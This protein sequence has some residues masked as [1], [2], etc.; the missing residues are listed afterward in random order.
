VCVGQEASL[1]V[2]AVRSVSAND[3]GPAIETIV[4]AFDADPVA[5]WTWPQSHQYLAGMPRLVRALAGK[6]FTQGGA[7]CTEAYTG[8]AL[9]LPP[10]AYP[11]EDMLADVMQSTVSPSHR[12]EVAATFEQMAQYHPNEPHW[13]LP[14]IGVDPAYQGE[15]HGDALMAHALARCDRDRVPAYLESTNPRNMSLYLRHGFK[16]VGTIQA[17]SSPTLIPMLRRL[18]R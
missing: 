8:A 4:L 12:A 16:P 11:D 2:P 18:P 17:G 6:A 14:L 3:E 1:E 9:W 13:Y 7:Y 5:R 10:G 15:G